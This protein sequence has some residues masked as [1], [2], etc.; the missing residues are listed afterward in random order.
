MGLLAEESGHIAHLL[1][2]LEREGIVGYLALLDTDDIG[3]LPRLQ[4]LEL[5]WP[6]ANPIDIEG[7]D[8]KQLGPP[9]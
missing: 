2:G 4:R 3:V 8:L 6:G 9:P 1:E 7:D 5:V